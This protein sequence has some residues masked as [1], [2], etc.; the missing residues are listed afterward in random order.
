MH[1]FHDMQIIS[2]MMNFHT[3]LKIYPFFAFYSILSIVSNA[4]LI[5]IHQRKN[6]CN[7]KCMYIF[8]E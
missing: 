7:C 2:T 4:L 6:G 8:Y 5:R 3:Y 1:S